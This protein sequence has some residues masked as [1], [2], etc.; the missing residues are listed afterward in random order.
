MKL[1]ELFEGIDFVK[2]T[3]EQREIDIKKIKI[4]P[5]KVEKGDL[6]LILKEKM[7]EEYKEKAFD[8]GAAFMVEQSYGERNLCKHKILSARSREIF[9]RLSKKLNNNAC[10]KL[11]IIG[12]TG[13]NGKTS[14][15]KLIYDILNSSGKKTGLIGTT[16]IEYNGRHFEPSL[17]TPD[18]DQLHSVFSDM[19]AAGCEY[20]VMEVS[21][22]AIALKK[23]EGIMFD[24]LCLTNITQD[25][26]DFFGNMH[27]YSSAKL[28]FFTPEHA[29]QGVICIDDDYGRKLLSNIQIPSLSYGIN[30]PS[31]IF[32]IDIFSSFSGTSFT[33][34]CLDNIFV[35]NSRLVGDYNMNNTLAAVG[36]CFL[37]GI[38]MEEIKKGIMYSEPAVGRFNTISFNDINI[39]I[40]YAHTPDGLTKVLSTARMLTKGQLVCLFGCGGNRDKTKRK[41]MG[42]IAEL[43]SNKVFLTSDNPRFEKPMDIISDIEKGFVGNNHEVEVDR[44]LAIAKALSYCRKDDCLVI[45]GKG[46]ENYQD[47]NGQKIP[48]S[49]FDEV[50]S[51][52][53]SGLSPIDEGRGYGN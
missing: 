13:T 14:T 39:V 46:G 50:Y 23:L 11:K 2:L 48:Y 47:I 18:P 27:K 21:A 43:Y 40:D 49:D 12:I 44:K 19:V 31:D 37:C 32:A 9:A 30:N 26:L 28:S 1:A 17:T 33:C 38:N 34:N 52:F 10:D 8:N 7:P 6:C 22:H 25:H 29:K 53:R 36:A 24:V 3:D 35:G 41:L 16:G 5:D 51:F 45:A 42:G 4:E 20:A 15:A